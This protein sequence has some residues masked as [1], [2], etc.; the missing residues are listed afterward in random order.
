MP[1]P[2]AC[3]TRIFI[4]ELH[5]DNAG[6]DVNEF[7]EIAGPA[8]TSLDNVEVYLYREFNGTVYETIQLN[9]TIPDLDSG[10]GVLAFYI[11]P[12][13]NGPADGIA[14][15][16]NGTHV[17]EFISY[18]GNLTATDGPAVGLTSKDIGVAQILSPVNESLQLSGTGNNVTAFTWSGPYLNTFGTINTN[19]SFTPCL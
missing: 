3:E 18:E 12:I 10:F 2:P 14:L 15:V 11:S 13:Q 7:I 1:P 5:Y 4:N 9:G 19:Q 16:S 8:T 17:L 6:A